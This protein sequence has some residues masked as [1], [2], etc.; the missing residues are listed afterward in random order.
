MAY[1]Y[2]GNP[3][4]SGDGTDT[5]DFDS[6]GLPNLLEFAMNTDPT[7][8]NAGPGDLVLADGTMEFFYTRSKA[9]INDGIIFNVEWSDDLASPNWNTT[10]VTEVVVSEDN[11]V[12][13][14]RDSLSAGT[15]PRRLMRLRVIRP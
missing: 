11:M 15:G 2:F 10:G 7:Q 12:Q 9:A 4:D 8:S 13:H 14:V 5:N 1:S 6:D 3:E